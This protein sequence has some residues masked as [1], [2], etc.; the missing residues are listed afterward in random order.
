MKGVSKVAMDFK[1]G[2]FTLT[3]KEGNTLTPSAIRKVV[4]KRFTIPSIEVVGM[5]GKVSKTTAAAKFMAKGQKASYSLHD[6]KGKKLVA[7]LADGSI[8]AVSGKLTEKAVG[9]KTELVIEVASVK[10]EKAKKKS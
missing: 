8:A 1:A 6:A 5:A 7:K 4:R 10:A 3:V 9:K 2:L